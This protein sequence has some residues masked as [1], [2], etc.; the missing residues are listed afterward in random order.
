MPTMGYLHEGHLSLIREGRSRGDFLV[1]SIFVNPTQFGPREDFQAYPRD[2]KRDVQLMKP[3]RV[4]AVFYPDAREMYGAHFQTSIRLSCLPKYLCGRSRPTHFTG[5]ATVVAKLFNIVR[6]HVALFGEK[7]FQQLLVIRRMVEDLNFDVEVIGVPTVREPDGL[8][9]SSRN[10]YLTAEQRAAALSLFQSL[11]EAR[12]QVL[13][14]E[15]DAAKI[16]QRA[17]DRIRAYPE[18]TI[19]YVA[20]CDPETLQPLEKITRPALMALAVKI[21]KTRLIDNIMLCPEGMSGSDPGR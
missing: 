14:G 7:D 4:D 8:A 18:A 17:S 2:L 20:I 15:R 9:M 1:V 6:P 16:L 21:D 19:D 13:E 5:V 3:E 10:T 11:K 12:K